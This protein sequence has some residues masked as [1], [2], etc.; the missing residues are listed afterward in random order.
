MATLPKV[1]VLVVGSGASAVHAAY[2]LA[3]AGHSVRML[4]FGGR[5]TVYDGAIPAG[6]FSE[7][8]RNDPNQHRYFLGEHFEGIGFEYMGAGAQLTPPRQHVAADADQILPVASESF[9]PLQSLAEGGL[10]GAWGAGC[11]PFAGADFSRFPIGY[12]DLLPH[13]ETVAERI[14]VSGARD[15]LT[16]FFGD[17]HSMMPA[18]DVDTNGE[19]LLSRYQRQRDRLQRRGVYLGRPRLAILSQPHRGRQATRYWD[20][21]FWSDE[22]RSVYRPHFTVD[23]LRRFKHFTYCGQRLVLSFAEEKNGDVTVTVQNRENDTIE[24]HRARYLVLGA[25]AI[26]TARIVL[27]S[28][29]EYQRRVPIVCNP[30]TYIAYANL[31]V[32]GKPSKD[33]RHSL[34]QACMVYAPEG[35]KGTSTVGHFYSYRSLLLFRLMKDSALGFRESLRILRVLSPSLGV[36]ILQH[37]D[38]PSSQKYCQLKG[39]DQLAIEYGLSRSE[40]EEVDRVEAKIVGALRRLRVMKVRKIRP[41]H[42]AST[43]FAGTFPMATSSE[44]RLT[45]DPAGRLRATRRVF[46]VD[47]SVFPDLPS[48]GLTFTMMAN[49]NRIGCHVRKELE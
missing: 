37:R 42:A 34:A 12:G 21:D 15:D 26:G 32:L 39:D 10:G 31:N 7:V 41:G 3:E 49:A 13:Y 22:G 18:V 11:P 5:D 47:G 38:R 45:T 23:E 25:G 1:D 35:A 9:F 24:K 8:R 2:P 27:R 4:D 36:L 43:H 28:L 46:L 40:Q 33:A 16:P 44:D 20:M 19:T 30:H 17:L 48:K 6:P 14:G 29:G